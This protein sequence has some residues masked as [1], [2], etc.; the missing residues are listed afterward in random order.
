M[1]NLQFADDIDG[2]AGSEQELRSLISRLHQASVKYGMEISAEK[3]KTMT[4]NPAGISETIEVGG[5]ALGTVNSF[6]YLG[7]IVS[8]AGSKPEVLSRIAQTAS[9][10]AK[11]KPIW[12]DKNIS[13]RS[14]IKLMRTLVLSI[15]LYACESWTLTS[16]LER[17][18]SA[19]EM[20]CYRKILNITYIDH[21]TNET[22]RA[23]V[24]E[25]AGPQEEHR[26][27]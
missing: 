24:T 3:T 19:L 17:R 14:K 25:A 11:L 21:V 27:H 7:A 8:D 18:I 5:Q 4:N 15:F 2:L 26:I 23:I 6:K 9:A 20:R 12:R 22:V 16:E 13:L 1:S 10:M